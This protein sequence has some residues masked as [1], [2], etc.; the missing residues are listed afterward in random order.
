MKAWTAASRARSRTG[1]PSPGAAPASASYADPA[2]PG[3]A[4]PTS[5]DRVMRPNEGRT[6]E[7]RDIVEQADHTDLA[8]GAIAP[9][10]DSL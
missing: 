10:G 8:V 2:S 3:V 7:L 5:D 6:D 9:A 1:G 4:S